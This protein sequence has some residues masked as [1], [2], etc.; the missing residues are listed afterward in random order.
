[1][2]RR[3]Q[4][5]EFNTDTTMAAGT[6][7]INNLS[8]LLETELGRQLVD[9]TVTRMIVECNFKSVTSGAVMNVAWSA[10]VINR[11]IPVVNFPN[12]LAI[13]E[14]PWLWVRHFQQHFSA[15]ETSAGVFT[16]VPRDWSMDS[17]TQRKI[18]RD[19][20]LFL[21]TAHFSSTVLEFGL[22]MRILYRLGA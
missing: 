5:S 10:L 9:A 13:P 18:G 15:R 7:A 6:S 4:W 17:R 1:M 21:Q 3:F 19:D 20:S 14:A 11:A 8:A 16:S 12:T 22:T 2:A